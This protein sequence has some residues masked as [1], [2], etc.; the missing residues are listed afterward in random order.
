MDSCR[1]KAKVFYRGRQFGGPFF[2]RPARSCSN[3]CKSLNHPD[4]G[5]VI[6]NGKGVHR[7]VESEGSRRQTSGLTDRNLIQGRRP[8]MKLQMELKSDNYPRTVTVNQAGIR[9][10]EYVHNWGGLAGEPSGK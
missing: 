2:V 4:S 8:W 1:V 6:A 9:W 10:K 3:G 5:K 7:E